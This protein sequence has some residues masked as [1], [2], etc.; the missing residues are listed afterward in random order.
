MYLKQSNWGQSQLYIFS[1]KKYIPGLSRIAELRF[2][3]K[4]KII[5]VIVAKK[6]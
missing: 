3:K 6:N 1:H 5:V 4:E 2:Y